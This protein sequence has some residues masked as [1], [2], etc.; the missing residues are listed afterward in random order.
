MDD[1]VVILRQLYSEHLGDL[2][3]LEVLADKGPAIS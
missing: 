3:T 1:V 2:K